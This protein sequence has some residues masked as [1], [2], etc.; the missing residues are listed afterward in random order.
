[1]KVYTKGGDKGTTSLIGGKRV[2]K[3]HLRLEAY[4]S[5]DELNSV[6]GVLRETMR[7][8]PKLAAL[9]EWQLL[10]KVQNQL[11]NLGCELADPNFD[12]AKPMVPAIGETEV[13]ALEASIDAMTDKLPP[14]TQ[15]ILPGGH[16]IAAHAHVGRTVCRRAE[17]GLVA[18]RSSDDKI[19]EDGVHFLN[20]LSDWLFV[21]SR[22]VLLFVPGEETLWQKS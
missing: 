16:I 7:P 4:G 12:P 18:L 9:P 19:R 8:V 10:A 1:M 17:R 15:F 21:L 22:Y 11:F 2:L 14:L 20:R 3:D 5:V 6:L 13:N